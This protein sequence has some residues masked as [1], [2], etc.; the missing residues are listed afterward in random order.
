[1][2]VDDSMKMTEAEIQEALENCH[3]R[4]RIRN[5]WREFLEDQGVEFVA[6]ERQQEFIER[7]F[8]QQLPPTQMGILQG[9]KSVDY[10]TMQA[11]KAKM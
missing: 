5:K 9:R 8:E 11:Q 4:G 7:L 3:K 1:M 2:G 6:T 10:N